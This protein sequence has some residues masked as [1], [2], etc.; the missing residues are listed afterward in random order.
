MAATSTLLKLTPIQW[1]PS[2]SYMQHRHHPSVHFFCSKHQRKSNFVPLQIAVRYKQSTCFDADVRPDSDHIQIRKNS[3]EKISVQI[4]KTLDSLTK[5]AIAAVLLGLLLFYDPSCALAASGGRIGGNVF[6]STSRSS[7]SSSS[8]STTPSKSPSSSASS[9]WSTSSKKSA[10]RRKSAPSSSSSSTKPY[11]SRS[12]SASSYSSAYSKNSTPPRK[13]APSSWDSAPSSWNSAPPQN[14]APSSPNLTLSSE[15]SAQTSIGS[16]PPL[17]SAQ[18]QFYLIDIGISLAPVI[19]FVSVI[20]SKRSR[21]QNVT[22]THKTSV[23]KLQVTS[24]FSLN[25]RNSL[26]LGLLFCRIFIF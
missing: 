24:L 13:S 6:S 12:S 20:I 2:F 17:I 11:K 18:R 25:S 9:Y 8:S 3:F 1:N 10:P 23:I 7:E 15:V 4:K 21:N 22:N 5:P 26:S 16:A 19:Y 14:S